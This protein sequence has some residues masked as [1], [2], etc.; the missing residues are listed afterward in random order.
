LKS[1]GQALTTNPI[2]RKSRHAFSFSF[3]RA[4]AH[5]QP[6]SRPVAY[7]ITQPPTVGGIRLATALG[8]LWLT[9]KI[10][11]NY[12]IAL[13]KISF[14]KAQCA[15]KLHTR[16]QIALERK[17]LFSEFDSKRSI[18]STQ[19]RKGKQIQ[20]A[21]SNFHSCL[22]VQPSCTS[23][24]LTLQQIVVEALTR[25]VKEDHL[26]EIFG[27]Y[28]VIKDLTMPMNPTCMCHPIILQSQ[29]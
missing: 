23:T 7:K 6:Y 15:T 14:T 22:L 1:T 20:S 25:N 18:A 24:L 9:Y 26:R 11:F 5:A 12:S 2:A 16:Q 19:E 17:K 13:A 28:G 3:S 27:K 8:K 4:L 10:S 21:R 29:D